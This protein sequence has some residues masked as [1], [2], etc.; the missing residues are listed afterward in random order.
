M[1]AS[2]TTQLLDLKSKIRSL[3][4]KIRVVTATFRSKLAK[5]SEEKS[6][7]EE[8]TAEE[9]NRI[10]SNPSIISLSVVDGILSVETDVI[11]VVSCDIEYSVGRFR[12]EIHPQGYICSNGEYLY[13]K[14]FNLDKILESHNDGRTFH[15]PHVFKDGIPCLGNVKNVIR[16]LVNV[17]RYEDCID[18]CLQYLRSYTDD[19]HG[20]LHP[21]YWSIVK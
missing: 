9:F 20:A 12:I 18:V 5:V 21:K 16:I 1:Y 8:K 13:V 7:F 4:E 19:D 17:L 3:S 14:F 10:I 6:L 11:S 15:H 2:L